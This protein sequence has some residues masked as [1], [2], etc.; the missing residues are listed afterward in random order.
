[1]DYKDN[2]EIDDWFEQRKVQIKEGLAT[3]LEEDIPNKDVVELMLELLEGAK[4][5]HSMVDY[6]RSVK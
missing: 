3:A 1:M 4:I 6:N 5:N 2:S